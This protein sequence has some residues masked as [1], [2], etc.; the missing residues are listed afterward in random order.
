M[1]RAGLPDGS[2]LRAGTWI[3]T[4]AL[5]GVVV[6][7]AACSPVRSVAVGVKDAVGAKDNVCEFAFDGDGLPDLAVP[8]RD[9]DRLRLIGLR[10]GVVRELADI[11]LGGTV[12]TAI[13]P[14]GP[15]ALVFGL[16]DGRLM[17]LVY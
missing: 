12:G 9:R 16:A 1:P 3:G 13:V 2:I 4:V 8:S 10:G 14:A 15:G 17:V 5:I 11:D 6:V 7:L